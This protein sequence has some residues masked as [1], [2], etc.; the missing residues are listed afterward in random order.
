MFRLIY[1]PLALVLATAVGAPGSSAQIDRL[2]KKKEAQNTEDPKDSGDDTLQSMEMKT[3]PQSYTLAPTE[4]DSSEDEEEK[5]TFR[6]MG[7]M[8]VTATPMK[9]QDTTHEVTGWHI[10]AANPSYTDI[11]GARG[12][13]VERIDFGQSLVTMIRIDE[14]NDRPCGFMINAYGDDG[15]EREMKNCYNTGDYKSVRVDEGDN[16]AIMKLKVCHNGGGIGQVPNRVKGIRIS[17]HRITDTG[18]TDALTIR[19]SFERPNCKSWK[20]QVSCAEGSVATGVVA[21]FDEKRG[22]DDLRGLGLICRPIVKDY[23]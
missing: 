9:L 4:N 10:D 21:H 8:D 16:E 22:K 11:S 2:Y 7:T 18:E 17:G 13:V 23:G 14:R 15:L 12:D 5:P 1:V 3:A 6:S 20:N 19:D